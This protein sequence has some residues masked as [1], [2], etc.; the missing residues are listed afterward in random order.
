MKTKNYI[1]LPLLTFCMLH[2]EIFDAYPA[3]S[4]M[5]MDPLYIVRFSPDL[6]KIEFGYREDKWSLY[7]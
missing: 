4:Q 2:P 5:V 3:I 1:E 7:E 6:R